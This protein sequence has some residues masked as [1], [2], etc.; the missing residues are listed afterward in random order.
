MEAVSDCRGIGRSVRV[1]FV[2]VIRVVYSWTCVVLRCI[3][4][5]VPRSGGLT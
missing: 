2:W 1:Q 5:T 4:L 3:L